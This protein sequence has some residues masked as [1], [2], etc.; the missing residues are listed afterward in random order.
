[1]DGTPRERSAD[2]ALQRALSLHRAARLEEA[3]AAYEEVLRRDPRHTA[4]LTFLGA[5][6]L[7]CRQVERALALT[8]RALEVDPT[9]VAAHLVQ[10]HSLSRLGQHLA[11]LASYE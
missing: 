4:A 10:G 11:A 6:A 7:E 8:A 2:D 1:M 5:L 9:H 3:V